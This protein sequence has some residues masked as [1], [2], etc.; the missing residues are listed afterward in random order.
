M[1]ALN[2]FL[3]TSRQAELMKSGIHQI[4]KGMNLMKQICVYVH[5]T[6]EKMK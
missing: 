4:L 5:V 3:D 2:Q 1:N 6:N